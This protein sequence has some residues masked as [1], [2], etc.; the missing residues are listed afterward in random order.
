MLA[1]LRATTVY[2]LE[3]PDF[4][5]L[6]LHGGF[7]WGTEA[8]AAGSRGRTQAW[9]LAVE[10]LRATCQRCIEEGVFV[11]R[12]PG[13]IARTI[14]SMQ[15]VELAHW[16]EGDMATDPEVVA[17]DLE[18]QVVRAFRMPAAAP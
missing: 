12:D 9:R 4:L 13:L 1:G 16:L 17:E 6:R 7:T 11:D 8:M 5:K 3:Q 14:V 10:R 2:F 18:Q 15:Q